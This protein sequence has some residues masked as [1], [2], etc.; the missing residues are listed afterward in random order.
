MSSSVDLKLIG[1]P[2]RLVGRQGPALLPGS[3]QKA[4]DGA[5]E[6]AFL[7]HSLVPLRLLVQGPPFGNRRH[8]LQKP[9]HSVGK[10]RFTRP[11]ARC[12][13]WMGVTQAGSLC[14]GCAC[15]EGRQA[16]DEPTW[17]GRDVLKKGE[18]RGL[19]DKVTSE[20]SR[21][22]NGGRDGLGPGLSGPVGWVFG[23]LM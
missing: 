10:F 20:Q 1:T 6:L 16:A 5:R 23:S 21:K 7:T 2:G 14:W 19:P 11:C 15:R 22:E 3:D 17:L 9:I 13:P 18:G 12:S 8:G 4:W